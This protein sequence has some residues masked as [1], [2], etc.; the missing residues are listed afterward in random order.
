[1]MLRI[2]VLAASWAPAETILRGLWLESVG[3]RWCG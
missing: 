2:T 3:V 1:M